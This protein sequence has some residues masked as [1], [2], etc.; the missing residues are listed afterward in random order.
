MEKIKN[1]YLKNY[2]FRKMIHYIWYIVKC[3]I[4]GD[5]IGT[6]IGRPYL[7]KGKTKKSKIVRFV[8]YLIALIPVSVI[9]GWVEAEYCTLK[10]R[11]FDEDEEFDEWLEKNN[12]EN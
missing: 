6:K 4:L 1:K 11:K 7:A 9:I 2:E 3:S 8:I 5:W 10:D 12:K